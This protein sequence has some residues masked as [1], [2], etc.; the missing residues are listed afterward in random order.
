MT[1]PAAGHFDD[2]RWQQRWEQ[3]HQL[4]MPGRDA[5]LGA[6]LDL[7][8]IADADSDRPLDLLDVAGGPGPFAIAAAT[9]FP[10][11]NVT[12]ADID[13]ALLALAGM[14]IARLGLERRVHTVTV[15]LTGPAWGD[16]ARGPFDIIVVVM[17]LHWF[18][19]QRIEAVY[20]EAFRMLRPGGFLVNIDRIPD[21]GLNDLTANIDRLRR[22]DRAR[23]LAHGAETWDQW[24]TAFGND[25]RVADLVATRHQLFT[26]THQSAESHPDRPWHVGAL[27]R[28]GF[29]AFGEVWRK[30]VDAAI[31]ARR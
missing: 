4:Y 10:T 18:E 26:R 29:S 30:H 23:Q 6:V 16:T 7:V 2:E 11:V 31:I 3:T 21:G 1:L 19:P 24:W 22:S 27:R 25:D 28:A 9:R 17:A 13:P 12:L 15:D 8:E 20:E 5:A 14:T